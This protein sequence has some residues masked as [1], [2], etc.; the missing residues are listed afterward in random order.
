[1]RNGLRARL[2]ADRPCVN[3][4]L[5][6]SNGYGAE[7]MTRCSWDSL[8]VD[9]QHGVHDYASMVACFQGIR[10]SGI[11]PLARVASLDSGMIGKALD[12]GAWGIICPMI[13]SRQEAADFVSA[14]L[15][16]P[17]GRRSNGPNR[18]AGYGEPQ[19]SYQSF[20]NEEVLVIPMIETGEAVESL[21]DIL[22]VPGVSGVYI[23]PS[24]LAVSMGHPPT[25]DTEI[26]EILAIYRRIVAATH[27]RGQFAGIHCLSADY[28]A[29]MTQMGL[30][31]VTISSDGLLMTAGA[32][33][34]LDRFRSG[35][36][37]RE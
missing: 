30:Q 25:F 3:G 37:E 22:D 1:M 16:P 10:F 15:Y 18:A 27:R 32:L 17:L 14:C 20:A 5:S 12:A 26:P 21:D 19:A 2:A 28:A 9:L 7:L 24:D 33:Q 29:R 6:M 4:W 13:N 35:I 23:G 31:L 34:A 8:T 11:P 36:G